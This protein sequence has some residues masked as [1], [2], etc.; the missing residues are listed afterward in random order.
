MEIVIDALLTGAVRPLGDSGR[1]SGI[2]KHP[3]AAPLARRARAAR[4]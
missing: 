3:A 4:R 1:D 2:D